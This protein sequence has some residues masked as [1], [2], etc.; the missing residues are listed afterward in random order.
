MIASGHSRQCIPADTVL[1]PATT[2][3]LFGRATGL[4]EPG[5]REACHTA[6]RAHEHVSSLRDDA[7]HTAGFGMTETYLLAGC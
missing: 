3:D 6:A 2:L 1:K 5:R 7:R 4:P